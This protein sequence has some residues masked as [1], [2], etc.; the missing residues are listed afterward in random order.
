MNETLPVVLAVIL[1]PFLAIVA[2]SYLRA[3]GPHSRKM[4]REQA[5]LNR[6]NG[7]T[8]GTVVSA[9]TGGGQLERLTPYWPS[10][11]IVVVGIAA[12][13][14]GFNTQIR[15]ADA[16]SWSW[17]HWLPLL[18]IWGIVIA[19]IEVNGWP[20]GLHWAAFGVMLLLFVV[21]P[22]IGWVNEPP[23]PPKQ[24][25]RLTLL[26]PAN[27]YSDHVLPPV[28]YAT[29]FRGHGYTIHCVYSDGTEGIVGDQTRPCKNGN[30]LYQY[31]RD[32]TGSPNTVTYEFVRSNN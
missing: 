1:L 10:I 28:G 7:T 19:L 2:V 6:K 32:T 31:V 22:F 13:Y 21:L 9:T 18:I 4:A 14:W 5:E 20:K 26:V 8:S 16:G 25:A 11:L 24:V 29:T 23:K 15:P 12:V 3:V 17:N 30:M 27:G